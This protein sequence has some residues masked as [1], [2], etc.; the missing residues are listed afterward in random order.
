MAQATVGMLGGIIALV[1]GVSLPADASPI[2][3]RFSGLLAGDVNQVG[4][5]VNLVGVPF[6]ISIAGDSDAAFEFGHIAGLGT[7]YVNA[8]GAATWVVDGFG[9][10]TAES[11]Q[12]Y[13]I[14]GVARVG[15]GWN[16]QVFPLNTTQPA[17]RHFAFSG[18]P[19]ALD[20]NYGDLNAAVPSIPLSL[21]TELE[22][23]PGSIPAYTTWI[24]FPGQ[25]SLTLKEMTSLSYE[26]VPIPEPSTGALL[27][28][29]LAGISTGLRSSQA[30]RELRRPTRRCS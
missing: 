10:A 3:Y 28:L 22:N 27:I 6:E 20:P 8:G 14:P 29:G 1:A 21:L 5:P 11:A 17:E 4:N 15:F 2:E 7:A 9:T 25:G 12:I 19:F 16:G 13:S 23:P 30:R 26:V 24:Y 18:S